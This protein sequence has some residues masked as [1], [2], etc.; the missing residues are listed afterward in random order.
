M[1]KNK[2]ISRCKS[3]VI[4]GS[5]GSLK[6][7]LQI[8]PYLEFVPTFS[9][10]IILHRKNTEDSSLEEL[11]AMKTFLPVKEVEDK[12]PLKPGFIY[13]APPDYHL[14][15]EKNGFLSLDVSEKIN[16]SRPSIDVTFESAAVVFHSSLVGILLSGANADGTEG[17]KAIQKAGGTTIVQQPDTAD[18]PFMPNHAV[19]NTTPDFIL[20]IK[21]IL[22]ILENI[23]SP[24]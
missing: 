11:I 24:V 21:E 20:D 8:L 15:F 2:I 5:A 16:Y 1:E 13:I 23:N 7:L 10:V 9:I 12:T 4:G 17:L 3:V 19:L 14:L 6:V 22:N 18:M